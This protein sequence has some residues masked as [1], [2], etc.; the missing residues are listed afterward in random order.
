M[1]SKTKWTIGSINA[2][3]KAGGGC[4]FSRSTNRFFQDSTRNWGVVHH[5]SGRV[6]IRRNRVTNPMMKHALNQVR[7]FDV[8]T[9]SIGSPLSGEARAEL[10]L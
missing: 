5:A 4:F 1:D 3:N 10:N 6:F 8:A 9:G 7:E 2:A